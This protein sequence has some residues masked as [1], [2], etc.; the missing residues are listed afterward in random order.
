MHEGKKK[1]K[2]V[3]ARVQIW[4]F[5][6]FFFFFQTKKNFFFFSECVA[7]WRN[8]CSFYWFRTRSYLN[9][10]HTQ[11]HKS[12]HTQ[13]GLTTVSLLRLLLPSSFCR[14]SDTSY[15]LQHKCSEGRWSPYHHHETCS[16]SEGGG[17]GFTGWASLSLSLSSSLFLY[18]I[19]VHIG[20]FG[21]STSTSSRQG[22][23]LYAG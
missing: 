15:I 9:C 10:T 1:R 12:S 23:E 18:I 13:N 11:A 21:G 3:P 17:G 16:P 22:N 7:L 5:L 19:N 20:R 2:K 8:T 6:F 4:N 14:V